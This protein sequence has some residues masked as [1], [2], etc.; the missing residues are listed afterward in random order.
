MQEGREGIAEKWFA[1]KKSE[2]QIIDLKKKKKYKASKDPRVLEQF[3]DTLIQQ[4]CKVRRPLRRER[5]TKHFLKDDQ[6]LISE[7]LF[8][9]QSPTPPQAA[10]AH[11]YGGNKNGELRYASTDAAGHLFSRTAAPPPAYAVTER[12]D[13]AN[14]G[15]QALGKGQF[16]LRS[17]CR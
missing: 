3:R 15:C 2:L 16:M 17:S 12:G 14:Q 1:K 8:H 5:G 13:C 9:A 7:Q 11:R 4:K 6:S 10:C